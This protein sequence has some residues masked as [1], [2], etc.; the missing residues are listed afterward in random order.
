MGGGILR[1]HSVD[2]AIA[3][4]QEQS[5][6]FFLKPLVDVLKSALSRQRLF[7]TCPLAKNPIDYITPM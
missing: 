2:F 5:I 3:L 7:N 1:Y 4:K 6:T